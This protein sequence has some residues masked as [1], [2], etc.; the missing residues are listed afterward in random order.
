MRFT[1]GIIMNQIQKPVWFRLVRVRKKWI[2][3]W[4]F[5]MGVEKLPFDFISPGTGPTA[6]ADKVKSGARNVYGQAE[7][8]GNTGCYFH[9]ISS[10]PWCQAQN[11]SFSTNTFPFPL[12]A[13]FI[14]PIFVLMA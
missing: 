5:A 3:P 10:R 4:V 14:I 9:V 6:P 11:P 12:R 1:E 7:N 2:V 8:G 13:S